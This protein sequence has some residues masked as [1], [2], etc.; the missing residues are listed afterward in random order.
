MVAERDT[1][2]NAAGCEGLRQARDLMKNLVLR[3]A[4]ILLVNLPCHKVAHKNRQI[5]L[6]PLC[7]C[8]EQV[9]HILRFAGEGI[10][11]VTVA[12]SQNPEFSFRR[13]IE[14]NRRLTKHSF[15]FLS[16]YEI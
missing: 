14:V 9:E 11:F 16:M 8:V 4:A 5:R 15:T 6:Q 7:G 13:E 12:D 10:L 3:R 1:H 2:R